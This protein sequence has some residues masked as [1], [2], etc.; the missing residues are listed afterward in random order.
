[1]TADASL[2]TAPPPE[3]ALAPLVSSQQQQQPALSLR[4]GGGRSSLLFSRTAVGSSN[5]VADSQQQ[6]PSS[7]LRS[8]G[9]NSS[10]GFALRQPSK[11][12]ELRR[13]KPESERIRYTR[14]QLLSFQESY[15]Q[16]TSEIATS[17]ADLPSSLVEE[18]SDWARRDTNIQ[19]QLAPRV[20]EPDT[21]DWRTRT[22]QPPEE[23]SKD[24]PKEKFPREERSS[25]DPENST[26]QLSFRQQ[27][28]TLPQSESRVPPSIA[29]AASPWMPRR[30]DQDE[31]EKVFRTVKGI[32]NKLTPE[33]YEILL[34]QL[35][36]SG[37]NSAEIL[38][39]VISLIFDKAVLEPTFC[40][41]Y[42]E[43]CVRLSNALPEFPATEP[44]EKSI[45]FRRILLNTCQEEFEGA[46]ALRAEIRQMTAPE[47]ELERLEKERKVKLRTLGN[48]KFIGELFKQKMIPE[49]IVHACIQELIGPADSKAVPAEENVEAL[50]QLLLTVGKQLEESVKSRIAIDKY[51]IRLKD[52]ILSPR[53]PSRLKFMVRDL[54][55]LRSN[56]WVPRREEVKA[57]TINEIHAEAEQKLG[58]RP[59]SVAGLRGGSGIGVH[60]NIGKDSLFMPGAPRPGGMMPGMP[61]LRPGGPGMPGLRP[62]VPGFIPGLEAE[63]WET[64][65]IGGR[66]NK[67][68]GAGL[69]PTPIGV[70]LGRI[71]VPP[72]RPTN[73]GPNFGS[74][75]LPQGN[76]AL[77]LGKPSALL[78]NSTGG[79]LLNARPFYGLLDA[80]SQTSAN[81]TKSAV[82]TGII[83][84][85]PDKE[86][87]PER[88]LPQGAA[89]SAQQAT[90]LQK[91]SES[92]LL[93][94]FAVADLG[95]A[96]L[97][98]QELQSP[99]YHPKFAQLALLLGF[100]KHDRERELVLKLLKHLHS[101]SVFSNE[102]VRAGIFL[103][104]EQLEDLAMD[105]PLAPKQLGEVV[106]GLILSGALQ[107]AI[108]RE[109]LEKIEDDLQLRRVLFAA[110]IKSI[111]VSD[112]E[113][114]LNISG[115]E[116]LDC[117]NLI[118]GSTD[119]D[120]ADFL[121]REGISL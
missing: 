14:S 97:C 103:V 2:T 64:V 94:Y 100:E 4:P 27:E 17:I 59:G 105:T 62:I 20:V 48:I 52:F 110:T 44:N 101:Q 68:D 23:R 51:F 6:A 12:L 8:S 35:L 89:I 95:E 63:G 98:V 46:D 78:G 70:P 30:G 25:R 9:F 50:C 73:V 87:V 26:S 102:Q 34:E 28:F 57:K 93:E 109:I 55:D 114:I 58:L 91:K 19:S 90:D 119:S 40:P 80:A 120:L 11:D 43:L 10:S 45:T 96:L 117:K 82:P 47:Q 18:E 72:S 36:Q 74:R 32:L 116:L 5:G 21:R 38:Q 61:G 41:M 49:K 83:S 37:I 54:M 76:S 106:A 81:P 111:R 77:L 115:R 1:M 7:V 99:E 3:P 15:Q 39:G 60:M 86:M 79:S 108:L 112:G 13:Q 113:R 65:G 107:L 71:A 31:K 85:D 56:K 121:Q 16:V 53:L 84:R 29:K 22:P 92:L 66:K 33:K 75:A 24:S 69:F 42:S 88:V 118:R 67:R 104:G